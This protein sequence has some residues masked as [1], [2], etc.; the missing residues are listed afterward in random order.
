MAV[1]PMPGAPCSS[2]WCFPGSSAHR[3]SSTCSSSRGGLQND[4]DT[5]RAAGSARTGGM[6]CSREQHFKSPFCPLCTMSQVDAETSERSNCRV[7]RKYSCSCLSRVFTLHPAKVS[8]N[9]LQDN[10]HWEPEA[11]GRWATSSRPHREHTPLGPTH[12]RANCS[13]VHVLQSLHPQAT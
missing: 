7:L 10:V 8:R 6:L 1:L 3:H 12:G 9:R 5:V 2:A 13:A 11:C 4:E